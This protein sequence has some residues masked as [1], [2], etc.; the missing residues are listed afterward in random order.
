MADIA[1]IK[2]ADRTIE[3]VHP[4]TGAA[5]G[6]RINLVSIDDERLA[7]LRRSITDRRLA[8]EQRRK[9][10]KAEDIEANVI[11]ICFTA[12]LGWEWYNPT[13]KAGDE[14]YDADAALTWQGSVPDFTRKNVAAIL[15]DEGMSWFKDQINEA[16]SETKDFFKAS[17][18]L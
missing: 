3:I 15:S 13:G 4:A 16:I 12:M 7:K 2:S 1:S 5:I 18:P 8:L 6:V 14:G 17:K 11:D 9:T 10:F